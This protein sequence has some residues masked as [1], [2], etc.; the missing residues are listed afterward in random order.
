MPLPLVVD[1]LDT[2][3]E[4]ARAAY[5]EKDGKF[6]LD[7]EIEDTSGIKAKNAD[8]IARNKQ[9][10]ERAKL[11]GDRTPEEIQADLELA[12]KTKE[13]RAKAEGDFETLKGEMVSKHTK[14]LTAAQEE[15][16][17]VEAKL[18]DVLG[19]REAEK[20]IAALGIKPKALLPHVLPHIKVEIVDGEYEAIVIDPKTKKQRIKDGQATPMT[21]KD[22]VAEIAADPDFD[23]IVPASGANGGGARNAAAA[24]GAGGAVIIPRDASPT[25]YARL[26]EDA[27]KR[28]VPYRVASA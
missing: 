12:A 3:P 15:K 10:A 28:G 26:K 22:L 8:L 1:K 7:A 6:V 16:A 2:V 24:G 19:K 21:I 25:E 4:G 23:G 11:L 27:K 5:V 14:E 20:E 13:A 18:F 9:L 17:R